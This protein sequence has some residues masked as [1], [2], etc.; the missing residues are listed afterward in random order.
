LA[1]IDHPKARREILSQPET[2]AIIIYIKNNP[3]TTV[4]KVAKQ[5]KKD[6]ICS[7]LTTIKK[8][9]FLLDA[10]VIRDDRK[11][12]YF[13]SLYFEEEIDPR[14]FIM[15][16]LLYDIS[17]ARESSDRYSHDD[18]YS[19]MFDEIYSIVNE[20]KERLRNVGYA[21]PERDKQVKKKGK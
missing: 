19:E 12:K 7:R 2:Q 3:G 17:Y 18:K 5:M 8:I 13:H 9:D 6:K 11:G 10:G 14:Y 15:Q 20:Q 21:L 1:H 4:D 16:T